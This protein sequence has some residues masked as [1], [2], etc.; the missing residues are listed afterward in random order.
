MGVHP[1]ILDHVKRALERALEPGVRVRV[2][3]TPLKLDYRRVF[4]WSRG[5]LKSWEVN[6]EVARALSLYLEN[7]SRLV[8][9]VCAGDAYYEGL[10]FVFGLASVEKR[11]ASVYTAR[12]AEIEP[13]R[14]LERLVKEVLHE[15]GHLLGLEH[16]Y[17][18]CVMRFSNNLL[19]VDEKPA[20]F[21]SKCSARVRRVLDKA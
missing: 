8:V 3:L 1:Q 7:P 9:A 20:R 6:E 10:N 5:Q 19:E 14:F 18:E 13:E 21:C 16:C 12:L 4:D 17:N 11:V 15:L 2:S